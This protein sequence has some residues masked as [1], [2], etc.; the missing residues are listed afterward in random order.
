LIQQAQG[1]YPGILVVRHD[2]DP[3]RDLTAKGIVSAIR[4]LEA[5]G[6]PI[7]N[8]LVILNHWR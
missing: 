1:Q 4:K 6:V 3:S 8:Q 2:N 5:A 7:E